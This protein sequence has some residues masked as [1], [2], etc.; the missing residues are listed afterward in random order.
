[1]VPVKKNIENFTFGIIF[2]LLILLVTSYLLLYENFWY[3]QFGDRDLIRSY[4]LLD[5]FQLYGPELNHLN[6][7]RSI[8]GFLYYYIF[9]I[10]LI[11]QKIQYIFLFSLSFNI[12]SLF[13]LGLVVYKIFDFKIALITLFLIFSSSLLFELLFRLWNPSFGFGFMILAYSFVL[14]NIIKIKNTYIVL[15]TLFGL[16]AFQFHST[17]ILPIICGYFY[18]IK[19]SSNKFK[20]FLKI[21]FSF[22]IIFILLFSHSI[23]YFKKKNLEKYDYG[24][25]NFEENILNKEKITIFV[26]NENTNISK[27]NINKNIQNLTIDNNFKSIFYLQDFQK[28]YLGKFYNTY[29]KYLSKVAKK[30][31]LLFTYTEGWIYFNISFPSVFLILFSYWL[32]LKNPNSNFFNKYW[33]KN[34]YIIHFLFIL[35]LI[36]SVGYLLFYKKLEIGLDRRYFIVVA[37]ILSI[38]V[39]YALVSIYENYKFKKFILL[40]IIFF[41]FIKSLFALDYLTDNYSARFNHKFKNSIKELLINNLKLTDDEIYSKVLV[42]S[43]IENKNIFPPNLTIDYTLNEDKNIRDSY[44]NLHKNNYCYLF[45]DISEFKFNKEKKLSTSEISL[46]KNKKIVETKQFNNFILFK[47]FNDYPCYNNLSNDYVPNINEINTFKILNDK[48]VNTLYHIEQNDNKFYLAKILLN[49]TYKPGLN[50]DQ[51]IVN[52]PLHLGINLIDNKSEIYFRIFSFQ[53]RNNVN[54][55]GNLAGYNFNN[56]KIQLINKKTDEI[57]QFAEYKDIKFGDDPSLLKSPFD[58]VIPLEFDKNIKFNIRVIFENINNNIEWL[59][60]DD[61][62]TVVIDLKID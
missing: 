60:M 50:L 48:E 45:L 23:Y 16:I 58:I 37:P 28:K 51:E 26:E 9:T 54:I 39:S 3:F 42:G 44:F 57:L 18:V 22:T 10:Q 7:H 43:V 40:L 1:M 30:I 61:K 27:D 35:I 53:L 34:S 49:E 56:I 6:G 47:Y 25:S 29:K 17:Y 59:E 4:N 12:I 14:L 36:T 8:G 21:L 2:I 33:K 15:F 46:L 41:G 13:F 32:Y 20:D 52:I 11:T 62:N 5:N 55:G 19:N 38:L 24:N 31:R